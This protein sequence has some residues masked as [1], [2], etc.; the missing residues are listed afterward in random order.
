MI[1]A[2][3]IVGFKNLK[4]FNTEFNPGLNIIIGDNDA[5]K[6]TILEAINLVVS[7]QISGKSI[8]AD[9]SPY[10][11]NAEN[12]EEFISKIGLPECRPPKIIIEATFKESEQTNRYRGTN[13]LDRVDLPGV[14]MVID[15]DPDFS[16]EY[17]HYIESRGEVHSVPT[18]FYGISWNFFNG[19]PIGTRGGQLKST[20]IDAAAIRFTSGSDRFINR[21]VNDTLTEKDKARLSIEYRK[22]KESFSQIEEVKAINEGLATKGRLVTSK[23]FKVS[24]DISAKSG[25]DTILIPYLDAIPFQYIGMGE[26]SKLKI[27]FAL[28]AT[29]DKTAVFLIEEPENHLSFSNMATLIEHISK[30]CTDRQVIIS[31]H[32]AFVLNKL[33]IDNLQLIHNKSILRL[34]DLDPTTVSYFKRLPGYD[35]LRIILSKHVILVEGPSEELLIQR[36]YFDMHELIPISVGI[37]IVSVR[38][39]AFRRFLEIAAKL[40]KRTTVVTDNDGNLE[41]L[42]KKYQD[43]E[44]EKTIKIFF[45]SDEALATLEVAVCACNTLDAMNLVLGKSYSDKEK[46]LEYMLANKTEWALKVF[47]H[48]EKIEYPEY[49]KNAI[50]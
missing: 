22:L 43:F 47:E 36:L 27:G 32:S 8:F 49:L 18:E 21:V 20:Y 5:G 16:E 23:D 29:I 25:W 35:T 7:G 44:A 4:D 6:T 33:G 50:R 26:Q 2:I 19:N 30:M 13:N 37:D 1:S 11:F 14:S 28:S 38:G 10:I 46:L 42:K 40:K 3:R 41:K 45:P 15:L 39:L 12:V 17:R 9:I 31:T 48:S 24:V 34:K